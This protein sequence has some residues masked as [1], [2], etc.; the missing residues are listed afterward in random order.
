M[1]SFVWSSFSWFW[2]CKLTPRYL[3]PTNCSFYC[4]C[5]FFL[6]IG[7][8]KKNIGVEFII[9]EEAQGNFFFYLGPNRLQSHHCSNGI[10]YD[11]RL[12]WMH[13][14]HNICWQYQL[15]CEQ[16]TLDTVFVISKGSAIILLHCSSN[17]TMSCM[18]AQMKSI[19]TSAVNSLSSTPV[20]SCGFKLVVVSL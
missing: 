13:H 1:R 12:M 15:W 2:L 10:I 14:T 4:F 9:L 6:N 3:V 7:N 16:S 18:Q 11:V 20:F 8:N 17:N 5:L 19:Y